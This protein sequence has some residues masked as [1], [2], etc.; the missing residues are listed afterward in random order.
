MDEAEKL[1]R[2]VLQVGLFLYVVA[3]SLLSGAVAVR[4]AIA[5]SSRGWLMFAAMTAIAAAI[6]FYGRVLRSAAKKAKP[7]DAA[8]DATPEH[9]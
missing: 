3:L 8:A 9:P 4:E 6:A 1:R 5:D 7:S 2:L